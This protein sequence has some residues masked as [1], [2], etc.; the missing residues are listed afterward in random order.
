[1]QRHH[2]LEQAAG[3]R[4][5]LGVPD[6]RLDRAERAPLPVRA[7][8]FVEDLAQRGELGDITGFGPGAVRFHEPDRFRTVAG[9]LIRATK[10]FGLAD[11]ARRVDALGPAVRRRADAADHRVDPVAIALGVV[12]TLQREHREPFAQ[13]GAV[14]L[15]GEGT[16]VAGRRERGDLGE[17][18]EH[19]DVVEGVDAA[20][21]HHV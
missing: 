4:R 16:A 20:G 10:G 7:P 9:S 6:L 13:H 18:H 5:A 17:A 14:R 2:G 15:V 8:R 1:M 19:E 21:D 3:A 11:R 12:E